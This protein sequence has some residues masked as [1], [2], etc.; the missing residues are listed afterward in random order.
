MTNSENLLTAS[1]RIVGRNKRY[2]IWFYM[3]N[4]LFASAGVST[5]SASAHAML[6]HSLLSDKLL[7]GFDAPVFVAMI[8]RPEFGP[9]QSASPPA[10]MF[11]VVFFLAS[12]I[13]M[14]G[15]LLG[16]AS[17][18]RISR[19][20]F[21]RASG[22]NVW[23]FLRLFLFFAVIAGI[24]GGI[25][26]GL[27]T[28]LHNA[29][30][31]T[32]NERLP[33]I[34]NWVGMVI[35]FLVLTLLRN[36]FD[37]AQADVVLQDQ[38]AVRKSLGAA[39]RALRNHRMRM[40]GTYVAIALVSAVILFGGIVLWNLAV[41]PA[42]VLGAFLISQFILV[43]LLTMRFWQRAAAVAFFERSAM[44]IP[45]PQPFFASTTPDVPATPVAGNV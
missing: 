2:V 7:H 12:L 1:A 23:R 17:D 33:D 11:A 32:S 44:Q 41:P 31:K 27:Q 9:L 20:E 35:V 26:I 15:V 18:H 4:L 24:C 39:W 36:W 8:S 25:L 28:S 38:N 42:S 45:E 10:T 43:A 21:F 13:F 5:F 30:D 16:Y 22:R 6:D 40:L 14:P 3:M 37:V 19:Q 34:V 29:A